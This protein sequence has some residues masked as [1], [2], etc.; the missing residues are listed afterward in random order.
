VKKYSLSGKLNPHQKEFFEDD[1]SKFL[2]MSGG[3][4]SGKSFGLILKSLRLSRLNQGFDGGLICPTFKDF[5]RDIYPLMS[6]ILEQNKI[7]ERYHKTEH[8]YEFPWSSGKLYVVS[9]ENQL[10]GPNW[11]YATI[12]ELTLI[13][14]VRYREVIGRVR[15][16]GST[17]PQIASCGTPEG[18]S[19]P[20]YE[21]FIE[22][23][24]PNAKVVY[25]STYANAINLSDDYVQS[26]EDSYDEAMK[27]AYIKGLWV[28]MLGDRH[29][30]SYDPSKNEDRTIVEDITAP[31]HVGLDFN[32]N[33]MTASLWQ[34][35]QQSIR[36]FGEIVIEGSSDTSQMAQA[37]K[38]RGITPD[39]AIL[40][41]DPA[42]L[43]RSTKGLPDVTILKNAGFMNIRVKTSHPRIRQRQLTV[44]NLL[45]KGILRI[46]PDECKWM[47]KDLIA[48]ETDKI[49]GEKKK[50]NPKLTHLSDGMDYMMDILYPLSGHKPNSRVEQYR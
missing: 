49:T 9:A 8:Y 47:K 31:V 3:Y 46:N 4:A 20:Y 17:C 37:L 35:Y 1:E 32:V 43:A 5:K 26:L 11:A 48:V 18:I 21:I 15:V 39:R 38:A 7:P 29:Y 19:S 36:C 45:D 14:L 34:Q 16:K 27:A 10:R 23:P 30:W 50:N 24:W 28:N 33:P 2:H 13:D 22:K 44:N 42:G 12:N 6:D 40:Y 25:G 41:P